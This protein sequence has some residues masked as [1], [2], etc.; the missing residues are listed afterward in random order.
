MQTKHLCVLIHSWTKGEVGAGHE[1]G[2]GPPV[3]YFYWPFQGGNSFVV[4]LCYKCLVFSCFH[5]SSLMPCGHLKGK[6]WP[7]G[8]CLCF[9]IPFLSLS[10]V[11][12]CVRC[13]TWLYRFLIFVTF[14]TCIAIFNKN[15]S[16]TEP[17]KISIPGLRSMVWINIGWGICCACVVVILCC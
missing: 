10:H 9:L 4:H 3:K 1:T 16:L 15:V 5:V 7:L 14:F 8:S 2:L 17:F 13:G 12:S 6:G 11:V